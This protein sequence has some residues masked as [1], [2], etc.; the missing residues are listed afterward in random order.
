MTIGFG[1]V[2]EYSRRRSPCPP[3]NSTTFKPRA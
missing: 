2:S 1:I 3:Q